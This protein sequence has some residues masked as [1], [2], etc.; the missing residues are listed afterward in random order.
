MGFGSDP[1]IQFTGQSADKEMRLPFAHTCGPTL[2]IPLVLN[3]ADVFAEK[4]DL[5]IIGG[6]CFGLT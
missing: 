1:E 5:A 2:F 6:Q 3:D 4:M